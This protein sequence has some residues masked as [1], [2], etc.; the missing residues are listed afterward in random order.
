MPPRYPSVSPPPNPQEIAT[1]I[2]LCFPDIFPSKNVG[3]I[4]HIKA[5]YSFVSPEI[6]ICP[7]VVALFSS[8]PTGIVSEPRNNGDGK[9][10]QT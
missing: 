4:L 6:N 3:F 10:K 1:P 2:K 7:E 9:T 5:H 8:L